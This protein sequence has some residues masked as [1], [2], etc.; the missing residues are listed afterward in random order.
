MTPKEKI[1]LRK[2]CN[3]LLDNIVNL[4]ISL[5]PELRYIQNLW[6]LGI[7]D[8]YQKGFYIYDR[9]SEEPYDT[10]V[11]ILPKVI[12]L[13]NEQF[14]EKSDIGDRIKRANIFTCLSRLGLAEKTDDFKLIPKE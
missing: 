12:K 11:R 5:F 3:F 1:E 13:I 14:P 8:R 6:A 2:D 10:V 7:I 9:F 4:H